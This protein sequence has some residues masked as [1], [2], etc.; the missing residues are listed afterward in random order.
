MLFIVLC[1]ILL[2]V[3]I[4]VLVMT[5]TLSKFFMD[6]SNYYHI[7]KQDLI[8]LYNNKLDMEHTR[9]YNKLNEKENRCDKLIRCLEYEY[10]IGSIIA[11][12]LTGFLLGI[13]L[14][15]LWG[16]RSN[17]HINSQHIENQNKYNTII[18]ELTN[19]QMQDVFLIRTKDVVDDVNEWNT[20][21]QQREMLSKNIWFGV[22]NPMSVYDGT[23]YIDIKEYIK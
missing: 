12:T 8:N 17:W 3:S 16:Y 22:Y 21:Y 2:G 4:I 14:L 13:S 10:R 19:E 6:R 11:T 18:E 23:N 5:H 9:L 15:V 20:A 7:K 1:G